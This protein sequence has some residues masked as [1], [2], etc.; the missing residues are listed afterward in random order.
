MNR[1]QV[2]QSM[3]D[4]LVNFNN[5]SR[6]EKLDFLNFNQLHHHRKINDIISIYMQNPEATILGSFDY[7]KN[8]STE[9]SVEFGQKASVRLWD[10][11]GRTKETLY[12]ITQTTL[13]EGFRFQETIVDERVLVNTIGELTG[14]DYL[15]GDFDLDEYNESLS[16]FIKSYI[17]KTVPT[18][19]NY[20][21]EQ[22]NLA[23]D[24]AK[25]NIIEEFGA[26]LE[27]DSYYQEIAQTVLETFDKTS[28]QGNLLRCLALGNNFSQEF[29]RQILANY[30][31]VTALTVE[32][33]EKQEELQQ[34]LEELEPNINFEEKAEILD[35]NINSK[36]NKSI[37]PGNKNISDETNSNVNIEPNILSELPSFTEEQIGVIKEIIPTFYEDSPSELSDDDYI[38]FF[39]E[40]RNNLITDSDL[41]ESAKV[42]TYRDFEF[43]LNDTINKYL[44]QNYPKQKQLYQFLLN[45]Q[46]IDFQRVLGKQI[47]EHIREQ[48]HFVS[49]KDEYI[50]LIEDVYS[51]LFDSYM[52]KQ[53]LKLQGQDVSGA[54]DTFDIETSDGRVQFGYN[55]IGR[56]SGTNDD[57][58]VVFWVST[59]K[60]EYSTKPMSVAIRSK[61]IDAFMLGLNDLDFD[62]VKV[63]YDTNDFNIEV[64]N[65]LATEWSDTFGKNHH[66]I[67]K[68]IEIPTEQ[69][70]EVV[71]EEVESV[72]NSQFK[73]GG[74]IGNGFLAVAGFRKATDEEVNIFN[75]VYDIRNNDKKENLA[76]SEDLTPTDKQL[77]L[78]EEVLSDML[79]EVEERKEQILFEW[80]GGLQRLQLYQATNQGRALI[81]SLD[82]QTSQLIPEETMLDNWTPEQK[83]TLRQRLCDAMEIHYEAKSKSESAVKEPSDK[84]ILQ[85]VFKYGSGFEQGK[86]RIQ[87][88]FSEH[89]FTLSKTK[90]AAFLKEECGVGGRGDGYFD[91]MTDSKGI[92]V[93]KPVERKF[94]WS[95]AVEYLA[96]AVISGKYLDSKDRL[97]YEA[98]K[99]EPKNIDYARARWREENTVPEK[100]QQTEISLF[101]FEDNYA[102]EVIPETEPII[103]G[104]KKSSDLANL[105]GHFDVDKNDKVPLQSDSDR[106]T[107]ISKPLI[108]YSFPVKS[109]YS[110]KAADKVQ[111]NI[112]ALQLLKELNTDKRKA[113]STEQEILAKYVGWGGLANTF[114]DESNP[115]F[116]KERENLKELVSTQEYSK[117]RKSSLTAYFTDPDIISHIYR[118][119]DDLGFKGG[120]VLDPSMGSGNFFSAMPEELKQESDLYGVE[121]ET[122]SGQ[123][124]KQ[125]HQTAN[126]QV[127]GFEA[128]NFANDSMDLVIT[129]VPFGQTYLT[130][131]KYDNNYAIHDYFIKKSLDI[132]HEGG[133]VAVITSTF[134]IDKQNDSFRKELASIANLVGA[135]RLPDTAFKSIAG[136]DVSSD[137]LIFQK[138]SS[139]ELNPIWIN[140]V[141]QADTLGNVV[142]FNNYFKE[143]YDKVLGEIKIKT[144][145]GGT[146][147]IQNKA[148]HDELM[149][150]LDIALN[151]ERNQNIAPLERQTEVFEVAKSNDD[152][153]SIEVL[154]NIA[155]FT[156]YV[157]D[158]R[159]YY[160]NG[161]NVELHQ[162]T[163]SINLKTN[164]DRKAQLE[165]YERNKD[166]I[167]DQ[168][169][170]F[171]TSYVGKGYFDSWNNFIPTTS[172]GK[173]NLPD[174]DVETLSKIAQNDA[175]FSNNKRYSFDPKTSQLTIETL[176]CTQ[177]FYHVDYN[178]AD[179]KA[180]EQMIDL[181]QTLQ[182]VL[183]VQHQPDF[184]E[185]YEPLRQI[186]NKKYDAFVSQYGAI[187]FRSNR[188]LMKKDDYYQFLASIED[189]VEDEQTKLPKYVK[190]TVFFEPTIQV[191]KGVVEVKSAADALLAS[192]NHRGTLDFDYMKDIYPHTKEEMVA[193]LGER[194]FYLGA[195]EYQVRED[196]LSGDVKT[197]LS[198]AMTNRDFDFEG[199]DWSRNI[200]ALEEVVPKDLMISEINYKFG[201]RFIPNTIYQKFLAEMLDQIPRGSDKANPDFVT[202]DY[203]KDSDVYRVELEM[204]NTYAVIDKYG[205]R[206][207]RKNQ[208]YAADKLATTLLNQRA[209]KIYQPDPDDPTG[210]KRILDSEATAAIQ[211]RGTELASQFEE[212]VMKSPEVQAE[213]VKIYN[214]RYN[215]SVVKLYDGSSLSVN[216]LAKQYQLIPHQ[217]NAVMRIVQERRAGLA[218]EVGSGKTLTLLASSMKLQELGVI[219][220]PMF[221]IPKPLVEQ[222]GREIYKYFPESKVLI[223]TTEDFSKDNRKRF[224]SRIANGNYN[225]IVIADSQFGKVAMS[226]EYQEFY[227]N[228]EIDQ[229]REALEN[230][231]S[232]NKYTVKRIERKIEGLEKRLENLQKTD[233]DTFINFEELGI[234]FLSVDEAHNFKNLAPYTQLENVKGVADTRSQKA[235][236]LMMKI[237]YLHRLYDNRNVVFSTGTPMSNSV[238]ELYTMMK[239][240]EPDVLERYGVANFDSW[241][242]SF[243]VIDNNFELTAAGTFKINRRFTKFGNVPE[244]MKMFRESWD[245][246]TSDMLDL[247]VPEAVT[248]PH[249]TTVTSAQAEYIDDLIQRATEIESGS[250]K[251]YE[252]NMLKIVGE[253]RKLTL[254]MRALDD[255]IYSDIDSDKLNQVVANVFQ[256]YQEND[257]KKSTQ[258]IFSDQSVPYKYRNSQTYNLDGTINTFSAYDEIKA[259]LVARGIPE[260]EIRFIHEATDKNKEAMMRDMR[261]GKIRVLIGSTSKA[262]TG[263]NVQDKLIAVHHL[264]VPWRPSDITQRN[265]RIIRQGNENPLVQI[266]FYIT[267]G[268]MDSF[269]WQTQEVKKNFIEQIMNGQSAAREMEEL[270]TDTPSPASF[271]AAANGNPLQAEFMKLDMEL[272][273]LKRSRTRFY[274]GKATDQNRIGEEKNRLSS[275]EKRLENVEKD[276]SNIK[277]TKGNPF[278]LE[279]SYNGQ[280]KYFNDQDKKSDVGEFFAKRLNCNVLQYQ[281]STERIDLTSLG[282]Y[283]GFE[284]VHQVASSNDNTNH[285]LVLKG[286]AQYSVRV[287]VSAPTGILTRIDNKIDEGI[288]RDFENTLNE[289]DRLRN[290]IN[291]IEEAENAPYPK[292][293]E[294]KE[295]MERYSDLKESLEAERSG[296]VRDV[297]NN[298]EQSEEIEM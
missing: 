235:M 121:I 264:D 44:V 50:S 21:T 23:L 120:R 48:A 47:F 112:R 268:S 253:N 266:H 94:T 289:I 8:L 181:R 186:L 29:S 295:K 184:E 18:L 191:E 137:I 62:D 109:I 75:K 145:N 190:G 81:V 211:E 131:D 226:K 178:K 274:E 277:E 291:K 166:K 95:K 270:T 192:L 216:G 7:W 281:V 65:M 205:F 280:S 171:V 276:L 224:I 143:H 4:F 257:E 85:E 104:Q 149:N 128:T 14:Q 71:L 40:L 262:G 117:M 154:E 88:Y 198:V 35:T 101:D 113:T 286:N 169:E 49:N 57:S 203:D 231:D 2:V 110:R 269:L 267:K 180:I 272:Q 142:T 176:E 124:S 172:E 259:K 140:T 199:Y 147:S 194:L 111:D 79:V 43:T 107:Q 129:N 217:Q 27:D 55:Y 108:D 189:E 123:L 284:L 80:S 260:Q 45:H 162:K 182:E 114:F 33:L 175:A 230:S 36:D 144:F 97:E 265:G 244:L 254:D 271:K 39:D 232:G 19:P 6:E 132:V 64:G 26:F 285:D 212:W 141:K 69:N 119:L 59:D 185:T 1:E 52:D 46:P 25:Y 61:I 99:S 103:E 263:L 138:T 209:P 98:W 84:E 225:A 234:D 31:R 130:D 227:I 72:N 241:V 74:V 242:S 292:E 165:R 82:L 92:E 248:T 206:N 51:K 201:T 139:P 152:S 151:F 168:K 58:K 16:R 89:E 68:V 153:I 279:L 159:P 208:S 106:S 96:E 258:M 252:D 134:T 15:L 41:I 229:S 283:R 249:Y 179:V 37:P 24:I 282:H 13:H 164:E 28:E 63:D 5:L 197:K 67:F 233:T 160:H 218:H 238:V 167:F 32:R 256:I 170:K 86:Q 20:S 215:R 174:I 127:K 115:R 237:E 90:A 290:A 56:E 148:S 188:S 9:S 219:S 195:D 122:L 278:S 223:A 213:I 297:T 275:F 155:P 187:S 105:S 255:S 157:H 293:E 245:I 125:L 100:E 273:V 287:D 11:N 78:A 150:A 136:T 60:E 193:E 177:Y 73:K 3:S 296:T 76:P 102:E 66:Q 70:T 202:I 222:F 83:D 133:Y 161:K 91:F 214:K 221:V 126:I 236:D 17:E 146:L 87:Y 196:Y 30:E 163:S 116:Q 240:I 250:V 158:N 53:N 54:Y 200:S 183:K 220:K 247:P 135:V 204:T 42:N 261:T 228:N 173:N 243:G 156:L 210:K 298:Y 251:P 12:D 22:I 77:Q 38:A 207:S 93:W 34:K 288:A 294:Y 118:Q 239:Y 10:E 246:Q